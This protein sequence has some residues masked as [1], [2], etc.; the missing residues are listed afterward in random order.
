MFFKIWNEISKVDPQ[1][2]FDPKIN[3]EN[4]SS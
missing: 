3:T 4:F 1:F 2:V